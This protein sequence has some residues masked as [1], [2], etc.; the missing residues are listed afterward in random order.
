MALS[1]AEDTM[2]PLK[3]L[4]HKVAAA[5]RSLHHLTA[6]RAAAENV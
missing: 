2:E 1:G 3:R 4:Y 5:A 6:E